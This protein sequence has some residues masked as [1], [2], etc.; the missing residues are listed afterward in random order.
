MS[1]YKYID[2]A[3]KGVAEALYPN[4]KYV[5]GTQDEVAQA[6]LEPDQVLFA[7]FAN[8]NLVKR[9]VS[10]NV[11]TA[12]NFGVY[13][14]LQDSI[15]SGSEEVDNIITTAEIMVNQL[16][17]TLESYYED[18]GINIT[19][20]ITYIPWYKRLGGTVTGVWCSFNLQ[21]AQCLPNTYPNLGE[22]FGKIGREVDP[23]DWVGILKNEQ[24]RIYQ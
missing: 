18:L 2:G 15:Q 7:I 21:V 23:F 16:L 24:A 17:E 3:F 4:L 11:A 22:Y 20:D 8:Y 10:D 1:T 13:I 12:N 9:E 19:G 6:E 14:G 5:K